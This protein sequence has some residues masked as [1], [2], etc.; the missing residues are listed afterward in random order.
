MKK[1]LLSMLMV[2]VVV[3]LGACSNEPKYEEG[4]TRITSNEDLKAIGGDKAT[5][6]EYLIYF[7]TDECVYC[8]KFRPILN[9]Y[10]GKDGAMPIYM[11][12]IAEQT[13]LELV[14]DLIKVHEGDLSIEGTP[15]LM[16]MKDGESVVMLPGLMELKDIP[17]KG[18]FDK[19][20]DGE[21]QGEIDAEGNITTK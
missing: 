7:M 12:D 19:F 15:T 9:E 1:I 13:S 18:D 14:K 10:V 11:F 16:Y 3:F 8:Q 2:F 5:E 20:A 6:G 17:V 4:I 21:I